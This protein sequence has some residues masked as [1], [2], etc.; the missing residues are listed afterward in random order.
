GLG[1]LSVHRDRFRELC[2]GR[3]A[4]GGK[5]IVVGGGG[6]LLERRLVVVVGR[7]VTQGGCRLEAVECHGRDIEVGADD[8]I[9][10]LREGAHA[11]CRPVAHGGIGHRGNVGQ[12]GGAITLPISH[13]VGGH[14]SLGVENCRSEQ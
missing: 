7:A 12:H 10:L 4:E 13:H 5:K 2:C 11:G 14:G 3:A 9:E 1:R 8:V 6:V